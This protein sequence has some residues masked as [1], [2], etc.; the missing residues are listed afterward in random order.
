MPLNNILEMEIFDIWEIDFMGH[1]FPSFSNQY[2]LVVVDCVSKWDETIALSTN[3][4][5]VVIEFF[6]KYIFT[7]YDTP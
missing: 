4:A 3:D 5:K 6:K 7:H 2:A 1:F